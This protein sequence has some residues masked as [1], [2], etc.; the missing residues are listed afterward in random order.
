MF[1]II[2]LKFS[3][4]ECT[5]VKTTRSYWSIFRPSDAP[6]RYKEQKNQL[7]VRC[8]LIKFSHHHASV[9]G[10]NELPWGSSASCQEQRRP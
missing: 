8:P 1:L 4:S 5:Y 6:A 9:E 7:C 2:Q 10:R 3:D